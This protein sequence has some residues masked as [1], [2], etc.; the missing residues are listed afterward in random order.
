MMKFEIGQ[1]LK[2]EGNIWEVCLIIKRQ[3]V[4]LHLST[5]EIQTH[6]QAL[7]EKAYMEDMLV[8]ANEREHE[9]P[10]NGLMFSDL[11]KFQRKTILFRMKFVNRLLVGDVTIYNA[12]A[13]IEDVANSIGCTKCPGEKTVR[14]WLTTYRRSGSDLKSLVDHRHPLVS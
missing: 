8:A 13:I 1:H 7:L 10:L 9:K 6:D 12:K 4:L 14:R 11:N 3:I 5:Q 2:W